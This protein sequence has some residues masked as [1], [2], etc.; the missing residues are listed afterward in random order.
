MRRMAHR[1][2]VLGVA[3]GLALAMSV[4]ASAA[5]P[6]TSGADCILQQIDE[7]GRVVGTS[8][9]RQGTVVGRFRCV[10]GQWQF[11]QP[12]LAQGE[13]ITAHEIQVDRAGVVSARRIVGPALS[14]DL[15]VAEISRI[16]QAV[17]G[18]RDAMIDRAIVAVDDGRTRTAEEIQ[19]LFDGRDATGLRV[20]GD[21]RPELASTTA[22]IIH[23][24]GGTPEGTVVYFSFWGALKAAWAWVVQKIEEVGDW[25]D[26]HCDWFGDDPITCHW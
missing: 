9:Q 5:S 24:V 25:I 10:A 2:A 6:Q 20:I 3:S 18:E 21:V 16:A 23:D 13:A 8:L 15:T 1:L 12:P 26:E 22:A 4:T 14:Y 7:H 11:V 17:T 19:A